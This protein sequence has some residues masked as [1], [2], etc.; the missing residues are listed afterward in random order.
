MAG[1]RAAAGDRAA[2][3]G[4][5]TAR[6]PA[7]DAA[8]PDIDVPAGSSPV[9]DAT[10]SPGEWEDA[11]HATMT[12]ATDWTVGVLFKHDGRHLY[13]A[14]TNLTGGG[15]ELYPEV[16]VGTV[17][18]GQVW[19]PTDH[20][21]HTSY[22]DCDSSGRPNDYS[23]CAPARPGWTANNF[24][25]S[26]G[27]DVE[28]QISFERLGIEPDPDRELRLAFAVTDTQTRW[29]LWPAAASLGSPAQWATARLR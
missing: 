7:A 17:V 14:F 6:V 27:A 28:M 8:T 20:W 5:V 2:T 4:Q 23:T 21:F 29:T 19:L 16:L 22:Q 18:E 25:L 26:A 15:D 10:V 11:G 12:I 3:E 1:S 24:P 13:V 9:I